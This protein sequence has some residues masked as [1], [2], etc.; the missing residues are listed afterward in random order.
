MVPT[1]TWFLQIPIQNLLYVQAGIKGVTSHVQFSLPAAVLNQ[2][3]QKSQQLLNF[4]NRECSGKQEQEAREQRR[5]GQAGP[6]AAST[7]RST[8]HSAT[9]PG[10]A[11]GRKENRIQMNT[12]LLSLQTQ[13]L[14]LAK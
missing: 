3:S 12:G 1:L 11:E 9:S 5:A 4:R 13:N 7:Q 10:R 8:S 6:A 2:Y 14:R